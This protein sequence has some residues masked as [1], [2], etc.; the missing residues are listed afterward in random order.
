MIRNWARN[1][2][3]V[4]VLAGILTACS[5]LKL[6]PYNLTTRIA[7]LPFNVPISFD[8]FTYD[9]QIHRVIIPAGETGQ[10]ALVDPA[11]MQVQLISGFSRQGDSANPIIGSTSAVVVGGVL[12]GL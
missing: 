6:N 8:D 9:S 1:A 4:L 5:G 3:L 10:V 12:Y 11:N 7:P 2:I